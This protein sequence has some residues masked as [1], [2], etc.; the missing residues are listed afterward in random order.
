MAP[1]LRD[2]SRGEGPGFAR[3]RAEY[4]P[5]GNGK[6][7]LPRTVIGLESSPSGASIQERILGNIRS[8]ASGQSRLL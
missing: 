3:H 2:A 1:F 5:A 6:H 7:D 8:A 4:G